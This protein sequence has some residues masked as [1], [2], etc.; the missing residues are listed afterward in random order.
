MTNSV[1]SS[2]TS[3]TQEV[4]NPSSF[5]FSIPPPNKYLSTPVCGVG[6]TDESTTPL[7]EIVASPILLSEEILPCSPTLVLSHDKSQSSE[8]QSIAKLGNDVSTKVASRDVSLIMSE[9]FFE[10]DLLEGR[11]PESNIL[12]AGAELVVAQS[13]ASL[14]RD[15]QPTYSEPDKRSQEHVPLSAEPIFDQTPKSFDI[16]NEEDEEELALRW[17][18]TVKRGGNTTL[19]EISDLN[20]ADT[21]PEAKHCVEPTKFE[22]EKKG[23]EKE[24]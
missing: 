14:R 17:N 9:R 13:L 7:T 20:V 21:A 23:K 15:T 8:A 18:R 2:K 1:S 6:E 10:G 4:E 5:N 19:V 24:S 3:I 16:K 11:G 22:M 12:A